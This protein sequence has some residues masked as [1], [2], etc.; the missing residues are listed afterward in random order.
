MK[1]YL[2]IFGRRNVHWRYFFLETICRRRLYRRYFDVEP[3]S[4]CARNLKLSLTTHVIETVIE[5]STGGQE[6]MRRAHRRSQT[7]RR[8]SDRHNA[9][10]AYRSRTGGKTGTTSSEKR[11]KKIPIFPSAR[12]SGQTTRMN[13][14][15]SRFGRE[16]QDLDD[17]GMT[18]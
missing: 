11:R 12:I 10:G 7:W 5:F 6:P 9:A 18:L 13:D 14:I 4:R 17:D 16:R 15:K 8:L 2:E 1:N 3:V